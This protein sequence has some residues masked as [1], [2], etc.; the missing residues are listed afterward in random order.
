MKDLFIYTII[1]AL[2]CIA[3]IYAYFIYKDKKCTTKIT[4]LT[5]QVKDTETAINKQI[6]T[7]NS[8]SSQLDKI[9]D[10]DEKIL[11]TKTINVK[12]GINHIFI[13]NGI[14]AVKG[15]L[16]SSDLMSIA[17]N[18]E[19]EIFRLYSTKYPIEDFS[20][21][22]KRYSMEISF[23][24]A[25]MFLPVFDVFINFDKKNFIFAEM[26]NA[27]YDYDF[28][29]GFMTKKINIK[30]GDLLNYYQPQNFLHLHDILDYKFR[31][32]IK[33]INSNCLESFETLITR[34]C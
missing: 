32:D 30:I 34:D 22:I 25:P 8:L 12:G 10:Y 5:S 3:P 11:N 1:I 23:I 13:V 24:G 28:V 17:V 4:T 20:I 18:D 15:T 6:E 33:I 7:I 29:I 26:L 31:Q 2:S 14:K 19:T 9:S 27:Y 21:S 16:K